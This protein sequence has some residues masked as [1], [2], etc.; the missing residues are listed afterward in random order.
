MFVNGNDKYGMR[1]RFGGHSLGDDR[2][3]LVDVHH[4]QRLV[5]FRMKA[6]HATSSIRLSHLEERIITGRRCWCGLEQRRKIVGEHERRLVLWVRLK[7]IAPHMSN[8]LSCC[9]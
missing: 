1:C 8:S 6:H 5:R 4:G 9:F 2:L 3:D 7:F